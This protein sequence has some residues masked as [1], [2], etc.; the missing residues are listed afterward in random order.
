MSPTLFIQNAVKALDAIEHKI[1]AAV[2]YDDISK[3]A[4]ELAIEQSRNI[5]FQNRHSSYSNE[6]VGLRKRNIELF[7]LAAKKGA[8]FLA[9]FD[10]A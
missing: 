8:E 2:S 6:M 10:E 3:I 4:M 7:N 1:P 5:K 9:N